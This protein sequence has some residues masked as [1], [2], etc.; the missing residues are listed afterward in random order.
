MYDKIASVEANFFPDSDSDQ[1]VCSDAVEHKSLPLSAIRG[2]VLSFDLYVPQDCDGWLVVAL[3][4][5][6]G[7]ILLDTQSYIEADALH[8][9]DEYHVALNLSVTEVGSKLGLA[10]KIKSQQIKNIEKK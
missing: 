10:P 7:Q 5:R 8:G 3:R 1:T 9:Q 4:A 2:Q 6:N